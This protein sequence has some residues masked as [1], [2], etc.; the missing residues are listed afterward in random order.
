MLG[1]FIRML[2]MWLTFSHTSYSEDKLYCQ[3]VKVSAFINGIGMAN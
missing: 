2:I 1:Q 3:L